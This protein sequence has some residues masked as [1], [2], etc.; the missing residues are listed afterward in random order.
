MNSDEAK[1]LYEGKF[2]YEIVKPKSGRYAGY[3]QL[4]G[5]LDN[6]FYAT[7]KL[8][9]ADLLW[10]NGEPKEYKFVQVIDGKPVAAFTNEEILV[11]D[12]EL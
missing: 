7:R 11:T 9:T 3:I 6:I 12:R 2:F 4:H 5:P 10:I 1:N 8:M